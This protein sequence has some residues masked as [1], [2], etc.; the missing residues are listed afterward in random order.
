MHTHKMR[1]K[2]ILS[3]H[4][5]LCTAIEIS[6]RIHLYILLINVR[7]LKTIFRGGGGEK[8]SFYTMS[9]TFQN[10]AAVSYNNF[11]CQIDT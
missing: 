4:G 9:I 5:Q 1:T 6:N 11:L 10:F 8:K 2:L 3:S 7:P